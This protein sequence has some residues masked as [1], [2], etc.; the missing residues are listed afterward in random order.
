MTQPLWHIAAPALAADVIH[1]IEDIDITVAVQRSQD[2]LHRLFCLIRLTYL[3]PGFHQPEGAGEKGTL[4]FSYP[5]VA[6]EHGAAVTQFLPD[7]T[8]GREHPLRIDR[9]A[10]AVNQRQRRVEA[11]VTAGVKEISLLLL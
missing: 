11:I 10:V 4:F 3:C 8:V 6:I 5:A 9:V 1:L 2:L 7:S